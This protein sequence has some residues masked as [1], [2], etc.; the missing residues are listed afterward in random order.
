M[1]EPTDRDE[2]SRHCV[3]DAV[4]P[5][6]PQ[7]QPDVFQR[8]AALL[9]ERLADMYL[10]VAPDGTI[11]DFRARRDVELYAACDPLA[12]PRMQD[13]LPPAVAQQ[14]ADALA[15]MQHHPEPSELEYTLALEGGEADFEA[16]LLPFGDGEMI[17]VVRNV[18][19]RRAH[20]KARERARQESERLSRL[21]SEF[22][23]NVSHEVRTPLNGIIGLT[24]MQWA[25][26][27]GE[28][29]V[30]LGRVLEL[31]RQLL[32]VIN[33]V[34]DSSKIDANR[35]EVESVPLSVRQVVAEAVSLVREQAAQKGLALHPEVSPQVPPDCLGDPLRLRQV[36]LN[37][38]T[39]A[40]KFTERGS[41]SVWAMVDGAQL[42]V[43]VS[44]TGIGISCE[45]LSHLFEPFRQADA[46]TTRRFGGTGLG[47]SI[48]R[49]LAR[50]MGGDIT[51]QSEPGRGSVFELRLP[52]QACTPAPREADAAAR[53]SATER[54]LQGV[55]VLVAEDN[56]VNRIIIEAALTT[57][58]ASVTL[59]GD[60]REAVHCVATE[61]GQPYDIVLMDIQMPV[62]DG[63]TATRRVHELD[64]ALPVVGQTA[65]AMAGERSLCRE[66]GMVAH[67]AKPIEI[68]QLVRTVQ[69]HARRH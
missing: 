54:R 40:V 28:T 15:A 31:S 51:V 58:G 27:D 12:R 56:E 42:V 25:R 50:L 69:Q 24:Q 48:S 6:T 53:W 11:L 66:A 61:N 26:A 14:F 59:A 22:M 68:E 41:V 10:R 9:L 1:V 49:R 33:D 29:K 44:D 5:K 37:L 30:A 65:H 47:L 13:V 2:A 57:E 43:R 23:A 4:A 45:Q 63:Y 64:P 52:L 3:P 19:D 35:L 60:G 8:E 38:L 34:L 16:R 55:R 7:S 39:N 17:A 32:A 36:V 18:S 20:E 67:L 62:M 21:R 46:S